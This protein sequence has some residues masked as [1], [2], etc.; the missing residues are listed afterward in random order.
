MT[1]YITL[2]KHY[3]EKGNSTP[4]K[5]STRFTAS[6]NTGQYTRAACAENNLGKKKYMK[7][8]C[9]S[10][11]ISPATILIDCYPPEQYSTCT[12]VMGTL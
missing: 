2:S 6:I 5:T 8:S 4:A 10:R 9:Y 1:Y 12:V 7:F 3:S 11:Q